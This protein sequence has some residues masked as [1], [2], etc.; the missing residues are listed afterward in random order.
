VKANKITVKLRE[1]YGE[2]R[3]TLDH[4]MQALDA[5]H[6]PRRARLMLRFV[7]LGLR[8]LAG[9]WTF[10]TRAEATSGP[11]IRDA[12]DQV[13]AQLGGRVAFLP[14]DLNVEVVETKHVSGSRRFPRVTLVL[15][16]AV[17]DKTRLLEWLRDNPDFGGV[18]TPEVVLTPAQSQ[19]ALPSAPKPKLGEHVEFEETTA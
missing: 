3:L 2:P 6:G 8:G 10:I 15:K 14:F 16:Y 1:T 11:D 13:R 19:L 7:V 9:L 5:K 17:E 12:F 18:V 4:E